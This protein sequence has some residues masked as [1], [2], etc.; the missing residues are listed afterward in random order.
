RQQRRCGSPAISTPCCS[1]RSAAT[2]AIL[3]LIGQEVGAIIGFIVG[4]IGGRDRAP[5]KREKMR[6]YPPNP[7]NRLDKSL[8]FDPAPSRLVPSFGAESG[9]K[10]GTNIGL[11]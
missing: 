11:T 6:V 4:E 7:R 1:T 3:P 5:Q 9:H 10:E 2:A 8:P